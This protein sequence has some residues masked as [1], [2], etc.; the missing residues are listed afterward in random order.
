MQFLV[1]GPILSQSIKNMFAIIR[2]DVLTVVASFLGC[3]ACTVVSQERTTKICYPKE[4]AELCISISSCMSLRSVCKEMCKNVDVSYGAIITAGQHAHHR[5]QATRHIA[6]QSE[7]LDDV[8]LHR[9]LNVVRTCCFPVHVDPCTATFINSTLKLDQAYLASINITKETDFEVTS[10][11][12][13]AEANWIEIQLV[14]MDG[15]IINLP[16]ELECATFRI[17]KSRYLNDSDVV[18]C[19]CDDRQYS[20]SLSLVFESF[21]MNELIFHILSIDSEKDASAWG[22]SSSS[23]SSKMMDQSHAL[24]DGLVAEGLVTTNMKRSKYL[25]AA[26]EKVTQKFVGSCSP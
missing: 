19:C 5:V 6:I 26:A 18:H 7:N 8:L 12:D 3:T 11:M 15:I 9:V 24:F 2:N 4:L 16:K 10:G 13:M 25:L 23:S 14:T 22:S 17:E 21:D 20:Y 1:Y